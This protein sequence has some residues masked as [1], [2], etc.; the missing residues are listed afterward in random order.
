MNLQE[1]HDRTGINKRKLRYCLDHGLVPGIT[2][3][4]DEVG[5]ARKFHEHTGVIIVCAANLLELGISHETIRRFLG[6]LTE[7]RLPKYPDTSLLSSVLS[8]RLPADAHLGDGVNVRIVVKGGRDGTETEYDSG[9]IAPGNP[10]RLAKDYAPLTIVTL[11]LG[12][13]FRQ[14]LDE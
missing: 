1:L 7:I 8:K 5:R 11:N 4:T 13:I 14:I 2:R 6:G 10:A 12:E 3:G 9:W